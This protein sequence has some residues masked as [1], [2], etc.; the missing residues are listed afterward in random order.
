[1]EVPGNAIIQDKR[2]KRGKDIQARK[3]EIKLSLF[4]ENIIVYVEYSKGS[5]YTY[6]HTHTHSTRTSK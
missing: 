3:E 4:E 1:M 5:V 2:H 6:T